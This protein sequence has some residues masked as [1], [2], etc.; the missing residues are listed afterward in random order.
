MQ[1][2]WEA[3]QAQKAFTEA[4][5]DFQSKCPVIKKQKAGHNYKYAPLSDI[6]A[7]IKD[8]LASCDLSYRFEQKHNAK[9]IEVICVVT[10]KD[11]HSEST[12]MVGHPDTSGSK[13]TIQ[14]A[15]STVTYL[16]RY[17]LIGALGI[18]T[19]DEDMDGRIGNEV[20]Y[21][22]LLTCIR[23]NIDEIYEIK[24]ALINDD[25]DTAVGTWSDLSRE[26]QMA[27]WVAPSKGGI[28]TTWERD[29]IKKK[30]L[31]AQK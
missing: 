13:N 8:T 24:S 20:D 18:T 7:Q 1:I 31:V 3:R 6:I 19:A 28:F 2:K 26:A 16:Q 14:A 12:G 22:P 11:G 15:G 21:L 23:E 29:C 10:H 5:T 25:I 30:V 17:T 27:L 4:V 9:E